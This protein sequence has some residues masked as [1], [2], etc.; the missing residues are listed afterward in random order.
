MLHQKDAID[1]NKTQIEKYKKSGE[2]STDFDLLCRRN[3]QG[4]GRE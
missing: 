4:L 3:I 1:F 2:K